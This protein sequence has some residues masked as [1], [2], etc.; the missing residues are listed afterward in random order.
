[1][2]LDNILP[3]PL[4]PAI[5]LVVHPFSKNKTLIAHGGG[6]TDTLQGLNIFYDYVLPQRILHIAK[7]TLYFGLC[8]F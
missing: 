3:I 2:I 4:Y 8:K 7:I 6:S 5:L 1:M